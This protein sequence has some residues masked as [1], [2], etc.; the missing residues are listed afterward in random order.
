[1]KTVYLPI[2]V[3]TREAESRV[4]EAAHLISM[5]CRV[6]IGQ[7]WSIF[8]NISKGVLPKGV[9][10]FKTMNKIQGN[11]MEP[12]K[13]AGFPIVGIDEEVL[14]AGCQ[15]SH[16]ICLSD[17]AANQCDA[18]FANDEEHAKHVRAKFPGLDV[19][20]TGNGRTDLLP[21]RVERIADQIEK[22]KAENFILF[23]ANYGTLNT[24]LGN[25]D[26][27]KNIASSANTLNAEEFDSVLTWEKT[28]FRSVIPLIDNIVR[29]YNVV[30]RPHP[31]ESGLWWQ[32]RYDGKARVV[33]G[34][35]PFPWLMAAKMV[36][37][38][39]CTTGYEAQMLG[40]PVLNFEPGPHP[41][42]ENRKLDQ[43]PTVKFLPDAVKEIKAFMEGRESIIQQPQQPSVVVDHCENVAE[44]LCSLAPD[45]D[46][47]FD[48]F[49]RY[50]RNPFQV[51][52][53]RIPYD[54]MCLLV[55][56]F[57]DERVDVTEL[58]DSVFLLERRN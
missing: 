47:G 20:V 6:V 58:D 54:E 23:N 50:P 14:G 19:R 56:D 36:L 42:Y 37:H 55:S 15:T 16:L 40:R 43:N 9:V 12:V 27:I 10:M 29:T 41:L 17:K 34:T 39:G 35:S 33:E 26:A 46:G 7:Q 21:E 22:L 38:T 49:T 57:T 51:G 5:G 3:A 11:M 28:N 30:I 52:K 8:S 44:E 4:R 32:Q 53:C 48:K 24:R 13:R 25:V 18:F 2:E 31:S 45:S 1:M